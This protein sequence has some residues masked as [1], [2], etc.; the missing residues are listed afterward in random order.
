MFQRKCSCHKSFFL[1]LSVEFYATLNLFQFCD[2][3]VKVGN[4][5]NTELDLY[6]KYFSI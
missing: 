2:D 3:D 6:Q 1:L 5:E 4:K